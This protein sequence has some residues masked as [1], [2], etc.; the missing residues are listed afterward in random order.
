[1]TFYYRSKTKRSI[2]LNTNIVGKKGISLRDYSIYDVFVFFFT[3]RERE[4][5]KKINNIKH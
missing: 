5:K 1:L 3:N 4:R 2:I